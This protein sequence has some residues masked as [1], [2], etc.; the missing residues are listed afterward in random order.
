MLTRRNAI[1]SVGAAAS[2][3]SMPAILPARAADLPNIRW[4]YILPPVAEMAGIFLLKPE[5]LKHHGK[6]Y[7]FEPKFLRGSPLVVTALAAN[8]IDRKSTRLNSS[9][10]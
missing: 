10:T 9:H 7:T 8:E 4:G 6:T 1:T 5:L 3:L 2:V